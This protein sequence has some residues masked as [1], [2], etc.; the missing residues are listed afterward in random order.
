MLITPLVLRSLLEEDVIGPFPG[1]LQVAGRD[2][3][4][5]EA[6]LLDHALGCHVVEERARLDAMQPKLA[7]RTLAHEAERRR[8]GALSV[9]LPRHP[10][11][12]VAALERAAHDV[13]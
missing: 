4:A 5:G 11:A 2:A 6:V 9:V 13:R 10:V 1:D 12:D 7:E 3:D 8:G